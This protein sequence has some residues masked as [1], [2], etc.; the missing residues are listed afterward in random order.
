MTAN[1]G[2]REMMTDDDAR[3]LMIRFFVTI[4]LNMVEK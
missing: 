1:R 3:G 4:R 2:R